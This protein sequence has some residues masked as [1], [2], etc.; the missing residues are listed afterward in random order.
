MFEEKK[1]STIIQRTNKQLHSD[2]A[3]GTFDMFVDL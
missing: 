3:F 1:A 2:E